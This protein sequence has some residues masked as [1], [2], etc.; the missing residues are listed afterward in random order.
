MK[1]E[2][3]LCL[4]DKELD[5][6]RENRNSRVYIFFIFIKYWLAGEKIWQFIKKKRKYK[7]KSWKTVEKEK[8]SLYPRENMILEKKGWG[9]KYPILGKNT[10]LS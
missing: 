5:V 2:K 6:S 9:Q 1:N 7:G 3:L 10:P 4:E 8:F